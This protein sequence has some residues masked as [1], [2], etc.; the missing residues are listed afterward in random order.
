[1][2]EPVKKTKGAPPSKDFDNKKSSNDD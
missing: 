2:L 1:M